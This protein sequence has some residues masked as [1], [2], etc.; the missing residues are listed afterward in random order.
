MCI[1]MYYIVADYPYLCMC[2]MVAHHQ[3]LNMCIRYVTCS[4]TTSSWASLHNM[5][6]NTSSI[7]FF[8]HDFS[9]Y[10]TWLSQMMYTLAGIIPMIWRE[11]THSCMCTCD[12]WL[13]DYLPAADFWVIPWRAGTHVYRWHD[14]FVFQTWLDQIWYQTVWSHTLVGSDIGVVFLW[15]NWGFSTKERRKAQCIYVTCLIRICDMTCSYMRQDSLTTLQRLSP[16]A[17]TEN[18][19]LAGSGSFIRTTS[20]TW[21]D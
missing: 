15:L 8:Q 17:V 20:Q 11:V 1:C 12:T 7:W 16:W 2:A 5:A 19:N 4:Q 14:S 10:E 18:S 13:I 6:G 21:P 3:L 9:M